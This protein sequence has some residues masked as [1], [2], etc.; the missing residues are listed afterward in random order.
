MKKKIL[1]NNQY[2][3][4]VRNTKDLSEK[5][6]LHFNRKKIIFLS[7]FFLLILMFFS[8]FLANSILTQ[9]LHPYLI[10]DQEDHKKIISIAQTVDVLKKDLQQQVLFIQTLQNIIEEPT[11]KNKAAQVQLIETLQKYHFSAPIK[12][13]I[14][15]ANFNKQHQH[16]GVDIVA[17]KNTPVVAVAN[18]VVLFSGYNEDTGWVMILQHANH[19]VSVYKHNKKLFKKIGQMVKKEEKIAVLGNSG[20]LTSGPHLHFELWYAHEAVNPEEYIHF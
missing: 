1:F 14:I 2:Q 18:G 5:T 19:Y 7:S 15:T 16:Y 8:L 4:I 17:S 9:W 3:L 10:K 6:Y 20:K 13:G 11:A 12:E